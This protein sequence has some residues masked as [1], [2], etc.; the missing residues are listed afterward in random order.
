MAIIA[1]G[2][3]GYCANYSG[4]AFCILCTVLVWI[5][6]TLGLFIKGIFG[7]VVVAEITIETA[8][9]L[10]GEELPDRRNIGE[11]WMMDLPLKNNGLKTAGLTSLYVCRAQ[12]VR[13]GLGN[14]MK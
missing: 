3:V 2:F 5:S 7:T 12:R 6:L 11:H 13:L 4:D 1:K 8:I 14:I 9:L 10:T